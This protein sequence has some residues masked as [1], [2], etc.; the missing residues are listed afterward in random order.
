MDEDFDPITRAAEL[1]C[2][3]DAVKPQPVEG[4]LTNTNFLVRDGGE[5]FFVR[6]GED[7][8]THGIMRFNELAAARA[9]A[10]AGISPA[11]VHSEEGVIVTRYIEGETLTPAD[12]RDPAI[13]GRIV[14]LIRS[15]HHDIPRYLRGPVL[16]FWPFQVIRGYVATVT[17]T[18]AQ[19]T[20]QMT[21]LLDRTAQ[22]EDAIGMV[23]IVFGHNDLLA[24]N[25][26]DDGDR[27]WLVDWEYA[28][29]NSPLFDLAGLATNNELSHDAESVL[30]EMYYG[31]RLD[32][33]LLH[34]YQ[35]MKCVSLLRESLWSMVSEIHSTLNIDFADYTKENLARFEREYDSFS[36]LSHG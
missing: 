24:A 12:V 8:P 9:A 23:E 10:A 22:L 28:G 18:D 30:L 35:A 21:D 32:D 27:L 1:D 14:P 26:I 15:C 2:W 33:H 19:R 6:I 7:N 20:P 11:I 17:A 3:S 16:M 4:G 36:R 29:F 13:L 34:R 25:I 31:P 5:S